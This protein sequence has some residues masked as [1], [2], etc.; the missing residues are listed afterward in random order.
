MAAERGEVAG[1]EV[2]WESMKVVSRKRLE[3]GDWVVVL[4]VVRTKPIPELPNVPLAINLAKTDEARK[5]I[6]IGIDIPNL[7]AR[8]L[9]LPLGT[10]KER[11]EILDKAFRLAEGLLLSSIVKRTDLE[12]RND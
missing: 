7:V 2:S 10:P 6:E 3:A 11:K 8:P 1:T 9:V 4:L 12:V 5:L